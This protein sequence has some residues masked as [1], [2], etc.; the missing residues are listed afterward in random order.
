MAHKDTASIQGY[1]PAVIIRSVSGQGTPHNGWIG[2]CPDKYSPAVNVG[3]ED[4]RQAVPVKI[5]ELC[6]AIIHDAVRGV[7]GFH[8]GPCCGHG[9][10]RGRD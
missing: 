6:E 4:I 5:N 9:I 2:V 3:F 7:Q 10:V 8:Q 1:S